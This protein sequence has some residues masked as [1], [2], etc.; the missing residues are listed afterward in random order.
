MT[1]NRHRWISEAAYYKAEIRDFEP[2]KELDDWLEAEIEYIKFQIKLFLLHCKEDGGMTFADLQRLAHI[3]G[4]AHPETIISK[5]ELIREIQIVSHHIS[6][7]Q[8]GNQTPCDEFEC[9]WRPECRKLIAVWY[10]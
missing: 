8:P 2:G 9:E 7:F 10:R 5:A 4:V 3:L 1:S 6:C